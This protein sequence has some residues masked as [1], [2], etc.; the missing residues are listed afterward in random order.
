MSGKVI[1]VKVDSVP[2]SIEF[3]VLIHPPF[4]KIPVN[5]LKYWIWEKIPFFFYIHYYVY[6]FF[7]GEFDAATDS[8]KKFCIFDAS[9]IFLK[10]GGYMIRQHF[11]VLA[12]SHFS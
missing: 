3:M 10:Q 2:G 4:I 5:Q 9:F 7:C 11:I 12:D 6:F 8:N 1:M